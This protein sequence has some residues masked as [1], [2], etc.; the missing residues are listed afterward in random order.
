MRSFKGLQHNNGAT[1]IEYGLGAALL[2]VGALAMLN[3]I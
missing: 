1:R 2:L 3:L